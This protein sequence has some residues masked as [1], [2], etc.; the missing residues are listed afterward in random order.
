[1]SDSIKLAS[2]NSWSYAKPQW[3][4]PP[5][6]IRCQKLTVREQYAAGVR[7]FDLRLKSNNYRWKAAHGMALFGD[8]YMADLDYLNGQGDCYVRVLLEYNKKPK[9]YETICILFYQE[10]HYMKKKFP[11]ITFFGGQ[12]KWDW[13]YV[14]YFGNPYPDIIDRY[15]STTSLFPSGIKFLKFIDDLWPWLY[16]KLRNRKSVKEYIAK[17]YFD[18]WL[19]LDFI[20]PKTINYVS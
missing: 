4:I 7:M 19:M 6:M 10:C 9:D 1:M 15:S 8:G 17:G 16:A 3:Y 12:R 20:N 14:F 11:N 18:K 5:F 2:H 13:E